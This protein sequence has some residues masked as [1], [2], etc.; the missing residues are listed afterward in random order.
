MKWVV[1]FAI[2]FIPMLIYTYYLRNESKWQEEVIK[3][4]NKEIIRLEN[5]LGELK[6]EK[7]RV[8]VKIRDPIYLKDS[9]AIGFDEPIFKSDEEPIRAML[10]HNLGKA[11][12]PYIEY[13]T[14]D[15]VIGARR[16][17]TARVIVYKKEDPNE[18][19]Q[20][21]CR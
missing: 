15:D 2:I 17:Y 13:K 5:E 1:L 12:E 10:A 8:V 20:G 19:I 21:L 4:K 7:P 3:K 14:H 16:I 6:A 11:I 18:C 9:I